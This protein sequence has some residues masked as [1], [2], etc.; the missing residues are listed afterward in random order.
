MGSQEF[1]L[2][3]PSWDPVAA[4]CR[5]FL[6]ADLPFGTYE[7]SAEQAVHSAMRIMKQG[8]MDAVKMEGE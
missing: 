5:P 2:V 8:Y 4:A 6:L 7:A 1:T 3:R